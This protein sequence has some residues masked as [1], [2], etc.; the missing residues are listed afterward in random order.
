MYGKLEL[1]AIL[2]YY[3]DIRVDR[4]T[5]ASQESWSLNLDMRTS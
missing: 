3:S 4:F 1:W 5:K 2:R